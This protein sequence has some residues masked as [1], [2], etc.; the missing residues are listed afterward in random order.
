MA[1]IQVYKHN[2]DTLL[3]TGTGTVDKKKQTARVDAWTDKPGVQVGTRYKLKAGAIYP[4]AN[5]T[6]VNLVPPLAEFNNVS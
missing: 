2:T 3:G 4:N 6:A 5:C 1:T